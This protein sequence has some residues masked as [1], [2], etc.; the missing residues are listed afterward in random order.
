MQ[1]GIDAL[2][3][4]TLLSAC[5]ETVSLQPSFW[6]NAILPY[7]LF[8]WM[9]P[10]F[11]ETKKFPLEHLILFA[12]HSSSLTLEY[13]FMSSHLWSFFQAWKGKALKFLFFSFLP[14]NWLVALYFVFSRFVYSS[15][16]VLSWIFDMFQFVSMKLG[17]WR[18]T[19]LPESGRRQRRVRQWC[20]L[21]TPTTFFSTDMD[22][23]WEKLW[24][25]MNVSWFQFCIS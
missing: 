21:G 13:A 10:L 25:N 22:S 15:A 11:Q 23:I 4:M 9:Q 7:F 1:H 18:R 14:W 12:S 3:G 6:C 8:F 19:K 16:S 24:F 17:K 5:L 2:P 20:L